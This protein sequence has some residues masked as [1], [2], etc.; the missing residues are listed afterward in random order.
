MNT[1]Y[2]DLKFGQGKEEVVRNVMR[3]AYDIDSKTDNS[4]HYHDIKVNDYCFVEVKADSYLK[5]T[6]KVLLELY[7]NKTTK[8]EGWLQYSDCDILACCADYKDGY[9]KTS[10]ILFFDFKPLREYIKQ[11]YFKGDF[12]QEDGFMEMEVEFHSK[13]K[14]SNI[15]I[16]V[17][18]VKRFI[19]S[20]FSTDNKTEI[21]SRESLKDFCDNCSPILA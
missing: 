21:Y 15:L 17:D 10:Y 9:K 20:K 12:N 1:F 6:N 11:K 4:S 14:A 5:Y 13:D 16:P 2:N 7:S 8:Q 19:I 18:E 3:I